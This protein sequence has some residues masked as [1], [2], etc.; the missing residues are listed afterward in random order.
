MPKFGFAPFA[1]NNWTNAKL[2]CEH[3]KINGVKK[4]KKKIK[5]NIYKI[6]KKKKKK[7][8]KKNWN[9]NW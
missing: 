5:K 8:K 1:S 9:W 6:K 7:K 2:F 3:A 4:K